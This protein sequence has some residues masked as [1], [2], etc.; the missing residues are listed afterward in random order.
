MLKLLRAVTAKVDQIP[1]SEGN[2][3]FDDSTNFLHLDFEDLT[4]GE[5][6]RKTVMAPSSAINISYDNS[7]SGLDATNVQD[8]LDLIVAL[9]TKMDSDVE[10]IVD[11]N[12]DI[13]FDN[14]TI[15]LSVSSE[16]GDL[17]Y[18][19]PIFNLEVSGDGYLLYEKTSEG[20][21]E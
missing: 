7:S 14:S 16:D 10:V 6:I 19:S 2:F 15:T 9:I 8:A 13:L 1:L 21:G 11:A 20:N 5:V 17:M 12:G 4:T 18:S 3:I